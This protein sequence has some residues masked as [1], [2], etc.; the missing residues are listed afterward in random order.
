MD[1]KGMPL[2][3]LVNPSSARGKTLKLLPRAEQALDA[4]RLVFR[5]QRTKGLEHGVEQALRAVEA[6]EV[7][8]GMSGDGLGGAIGGGP[9]GGGKP[10]RGPP[11][12]G[13]Q[14]PPPRPR[15][16]PRPPGGGGGGG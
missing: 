8:V 11:P 16:P 2:A 6:G 15:P 5:V 7:P 10:P 14:T 4:R 9:G 12:R 13:G 1:I 3:L